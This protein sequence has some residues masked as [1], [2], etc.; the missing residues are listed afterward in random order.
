MLACVSNIALT[1]YLRDMHDW[2]ETIMQSHTKGAAVD[3]LTDR[4]GPHAPAATAE[5]VSADKHMT[6]LGMTVN[7]GM[8]CSD[9]FELEQGNVHDENMQAA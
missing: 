5:E 6:G 4:R 2:C 1:A 9:A 7:A 3:R 8:I